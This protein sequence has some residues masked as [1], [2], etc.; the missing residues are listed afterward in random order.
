[1]QIAIAASTML[2]TLVSAAASRAPQSADRRGGV[3]RE[4]VAMLCIWALAALGCLLGAVDPPPGG[5]QTDFDSQL[6]DLVRVACTAALAV[7][8]MLGPGVAW[9]ALG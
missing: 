2:R 9:R 5:P 4:R 8:L 3:G 6:L 7:T 1:M